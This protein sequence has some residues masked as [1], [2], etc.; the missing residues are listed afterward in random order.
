MTLEIT[1]ATRLSLQ[2][3]QKQPSIVLSFD[4]IDT[5]F[6]SAT[7]LTPI[8]IGDDGLLIGDFVIG[9]SVELA[10]S[11]DSISFDSSG[12]GSTSTRINYQIS[13]DLG[14]GE[15]VTS[16]RVALVDTQANDIL[17]LLAADEFLGRKV[18]VLLTPDWTDTAFP[19][20]YVTIFRG[21]VDQ[22]DLPPGMVVFS[23]SHPDQ[24]KRQTIF[25]SAEGT[26]N[27]ALDASE[28][29]I[30]LTDASELLEQVAGPDGVTID[31][32]LLTYIRVDDEIIQYT[33]ISGNDLT[34]CTRGALGTTAAAHDIGADFK[35]FYRLNGNPVDLA[36]KIMLS[37]WGGAY[38]SS[39]AV[40]HFNYISSAE[41][42]ANTIY[43]EGVD[44]TE[45][46]GLTVGD[47]VTTTGSAEGANNVT[48]KTISAITVVG[49][50]SYITI[51]GVTFV[52]EFD[53]DA[54]ISFRSKYDTLADGLKMSPDEV[55][56]EQHEYFKDLFLS[57]LTYDLYVKDTIDS[58][59]EFL[60]K[61]IYKPM[62]A[63]SV[64]RNARSSMAFTVGPLPTQFIKTL[65]QSNVLN[66]D[67][68][69]KRR[70]LGR[71]FHNTIIYKYEESA[72]EDEFT[73]GYVDTNA[74]SRTQIPVGTRSFIVE[75]KGLRSPQAIVSAANRLLNRYAFGANYIENIKVTFA[76]GFNLEV[77][78]LVIIDG[79]S[80]KLN[81]ASTG[82]D[83]SE[84]RFYEIVSKDFDIKT[85][86]VTLSVIDTNFN[87]AGRY[88]LI[89][90]A[91]VVKS[92]LSASA[93]VIESSYASEFGDDEYRKWEDYG[94]IY[95]RV[96]NDDYS[97][98]ATAQIDNFSGNVVNLQ[99]SLGFTPS[100]GMLMELS[101]YSQAT[102]QI[103]LLYGHI[104]PS[105]LDFADGATAYIMI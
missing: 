77:S 80:L 44:V 48:S 14:V 17:S 9:A 55:D 71:N 69:Y 15:S 87:G 74:T 16:M 50:N 88:A 35:S 13:P 79:T 100:A 86:V 101:D 56:V 97:V 37:G 64:P 92:G 60:S 38:A 102:E 75:T 98:A 29:T 73:R 10:G 32:D 31:D 66:A 47:Y 93:F 62:A 78:D 18:R 33:G 36:L 81:D 3:I 51:D 40:S 8:R 91:S 20:D 104:A 63:Y 30:T 25:N 72:L 28:T 1:N 26:V 49:V 76:T 42:V 27:E 105:G 57:G 4:G 95:I 39:V 58:A 7:I 65:D 54:T 6:G 22:I 99:N 12:A 43:F 85:G 11:I 68:I 67:K 2:K 103:K 61:E 94:E 82:S 96:R 21:I 24:K 53:S 23:I 46:Y 90:P 59:K 70:G 5:K 34:G 84:S 52:D 45:V 41:T 83:T 19:E 89:S